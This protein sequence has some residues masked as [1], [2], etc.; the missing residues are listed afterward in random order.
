MA[1]NVEQNQEEKLKGS[2][3]RFLLLC[4]LP[5]LATLAGF[6]PFLAGFG[7]ANTLK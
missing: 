3:R 5:L 7:H 1:R 6:C 2:A 4:C